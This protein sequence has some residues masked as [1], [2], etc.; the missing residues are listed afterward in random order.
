M[1]SRKI[2]TRSFEDYQKIV[3]NKKA[4]FKR[5]LFGDTR[6]FIQTWGII[7]PENPMAKKM[8]DELNKKRRESL[9]ETLRNMHL[10]FLRIKGKYG[11]DEKSYFIINPTNED[12]EI[13][14]NDY[15]Q[16]A[17]IYAEMEWVIRKVKKGF[18]SE[19]VEEY[20]PSVTMYM[21]ERE[22]K[23]STEYQI[24]GIAD[25]VSDAR[26]AED[27]FSKFANFKFSIDF[28]WESDLDKVVVE[29]FSEYCH[30]GESSFVR[31]ITATL[32]NS[33]NARE[34]VMRRAVVYE[35]LKKYERRI[36]LFERAKRRFPN[37][38]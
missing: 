12:L 33:F 25:N 38:F 32:D 26:E 19:E 16:K 7:S 24:T 30:H 34:R 11:N 8:S 4:R 31:K 27:F 17:Y 9:E 29:R 21:M 28:L 6:G 18:G 13:L 37:K 23:H 20:V 35:T 14:A 2:G 1:N 5:G 10:E 3:E 36:S 15:G 22:N